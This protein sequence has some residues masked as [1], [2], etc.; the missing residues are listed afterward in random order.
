MPTP[1]ISIYTIQ[2]YKCFFLYFK[3][4]RKP[5][6]IDSSGSPK[7][8]KGGKKKNPWS[9]DSEASE[10]DISDDDMDGS[11]LESVKPEIRTPKR[12]AGMI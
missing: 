4:P 1:K 12:A 11:F 10:D 5:K 7:K 6:D 2:S 8:K 9:D 3:A